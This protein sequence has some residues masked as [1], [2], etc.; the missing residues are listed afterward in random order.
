M[1][2]SSPLAAM[3]PSSLPFG[4]WGC[5][6]GVPFSYPNC[7]GQYAGKLSFGPSSFNFKDLSKTKAPTDYF[8][9]KSVRD[10]SPTTTLAADLSQNFHIDRSPQ[11]PTPRRS[12]FSQNLFGTV[13]GRDRATTPPLLSSSPGPGNDSMDI[14][15][16]PHKAPFIPTRIGTSPTR[17][18]TH[19]NDLISSLPNAS[20]V[21]STE[22]SRQPAP[23][24]RRRLTLQRPSLSRT[25]VH[26]TTSV[27]VRN[28]RAES[29][30]PP[31]KFGNG[32]SLPSPSLVS[33][34]EYFASSPPKVKDQLTANTSLPVV[35]GPPRLKQPF[36]GL[37]GNLRNTGSPII[38]HVRKPSMPTQRPR[39]QF[40]RSLSMFEHPGDF[41]KQ[42]KA[43]ISSNGPMESI[44][45]IYE[46]P[47][48]QLP[49]FMSDEESL[50]RITKNT[51][52][53]ILD[54]KYG[55]HYDRS[56]VVDCRFEYEYKG[57]HIEGAINVNNKD[58]LAKQLLET[59]HVES[60]L[61]VFHCEYSA[62]RAPIMAKF[63]RHRDRA[64]N[65]HRYPLLT[66]P[67]VYILDGGYSSFFT[68][69]RFR[70]FPQNYVEMAA[71][72]H[73]NACERGLGKI[74]QQRTKLSR[75][76]TFAFGDHTLPMDDSPTAPNRQCSSTLM[77]GMEISVDRHL[78]SGRLPSRRMA[79]Y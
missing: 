42:E 61:L 50:P 78:D 52:I 24:E 3:Q 71:K 63:L 13:N 8:N 7:G 38:G 25:K 70:C 17:E 30:L 19:I 59:P 37:S 68:D 67:E 69:H 26:S 14:S 55:K 79:S 22:A 76:Q 40:R 41:L 6:N 47:Q 15:P 48:L 20:S 62:H 32:P 29:L 9:L 58:E 21:P 36:S 73:A 34:D 33:P 45:D 66:Y 31:F 28:D 10:S 77:M 57:G 39:K 72:E 16:L 4:Q 65:A 60:T 64:A 43:N 23:F 74:K 53:D 12:L 75:A 27:P 35:M 11:L 46:V 2:H 49:H 54:G 51:M 5:R 1:E 56:I 44:T 18:T